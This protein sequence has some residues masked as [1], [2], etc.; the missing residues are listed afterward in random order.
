M[1]I[2]KKLENGCLTLKVEGRL[3][4][5]TSPELEGELKFDGV[6]EVVFDFSSLE[7]ISS[8]GLR[9]LMSTQKAM[10]ACG[11]KMSILSPNEMVRSVFDITGMSSIFT[12]V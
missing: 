6:S 8:A 9:V 4:T 2:D 10:M 7:Y 5:N 11:G 3:D 1:K 12:I